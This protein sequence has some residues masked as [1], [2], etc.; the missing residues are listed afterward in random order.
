MWEKPQ[1]NQLQRLGQR[2]KPAWSSVA[3]REPKARQEEEPKRNPR[4]M[5]VGRPM[6]DRGREPREP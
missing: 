5:T 4:E 2:V 1:K 6:S 3:E